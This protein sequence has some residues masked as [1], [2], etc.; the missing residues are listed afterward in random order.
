MSSQLVSSCRVLS[1][2]VGEYDPE[3]NENYSPVLT[4]CAVPHFALAPG[5]SIC[6]EDCYQWAAAAAAD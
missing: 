4:L 2:E 1:H 3:R 6:E 5:Y